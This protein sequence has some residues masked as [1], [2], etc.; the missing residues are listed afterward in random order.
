MTELHELLWEYIGTCTF[1]RI[2]LRIILQIT[3]NILNCRKVRKIHK[4]RGLRI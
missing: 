2:I 1:I 4:G 3:Q